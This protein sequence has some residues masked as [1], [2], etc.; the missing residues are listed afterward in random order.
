MGH[1]YSDLDA[2]G[3]AVGM[4]SAARK[5]GKESYVVVN[6][7][8]SLAKL[9]INYLDE[10]D[11]NN[12]FITPASGIE[13]MTENTMII[14]VDTHNPDLVESKEVLARAKNLIVIDHHRLT[15]KSI[16]NAVMFYHE[17]TAS[18]ACEMVAEL[19]EY[20][21]ISSKIP[22]PVAEGMLSGIMLDTKNFIMKTNRTRDYYY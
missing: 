19:I 10:N 14:V 16:D 8:T 2:V 17:P 15:V 6:R 5:L 20:F 18:S 22:V 12:Y 9:L 11:I 1:R 7:D 3:A 13:R 4:C 21:G